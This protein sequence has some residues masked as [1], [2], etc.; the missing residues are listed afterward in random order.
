MSLT[1]QDPGARHQQLCDHRTRSQ[2]LS[3]SLRFHRHAVA[4]SL[5]KMQSS[6]CTQCP[7]CSTCPH[8]L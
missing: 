6:V 8:Q 1:V 7:S 3:Q 2:L 5:R 4:A